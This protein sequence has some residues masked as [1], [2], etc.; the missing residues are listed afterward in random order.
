MEILYKRQ[1]FLRT[2]RVDSGKLH[3]SG[4]PNHSGRAASVTHLQLEVH[5]K[6]VHDSGDKLPEV[7]S[8]LQHLE[9]RACLHQYC[10]ETDRAIEKRL[11]KSVPVL[12]SPRPFS[13]TN[14]F[15]RDMLSLRPPRGDCTRLHYTT[16]TSRMQRA[17]SCK[18]WIAHACAHSRFKS[19][20]ARSSSSRV[21]CS[22]A[23]PRGLNWRA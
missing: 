9:I 11:T 5:R 6:F 8:T 15:R 1:R 7:L 18:P 19:A 21:L 12:S 10:K 17:T 14:C 3:L 4:I 20:P 23:F 13:R 16:W 22:P 2:A